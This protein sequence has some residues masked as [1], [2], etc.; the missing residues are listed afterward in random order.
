[1]TQV[2]VGLGSNL[3]QPEKQIADAL[4]SLDGL[5][6]VVVTQC[7]SLYLSKPVGPQDQPDYINAVAVLETTLSPLDLLDQLQA[8]ETQQGRVR[9]KVRWGPRTLD[10][11]LLLYGDKKINNKRLTV[12]HPEMQNRDFVLIPLNEIAPDLVIPVLG[13]LSEL[14]NTMPCSGL[15]RLE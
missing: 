3:K 12:P 14:I 6:N 15:V 7:S 2:Y 13:P 10:L 9:G 4:A 11:D 1:M 8:I 5:A